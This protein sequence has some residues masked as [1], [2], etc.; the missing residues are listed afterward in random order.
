MRLCKAES[1]GLNHVTFNNSRD[2]LTA[3][4]IRGSKRVRSNSERGRD[5]LEGLMPVIEDWH[6]KRCFLMVR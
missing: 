5:W 3:A 6:A 4:R 2:Q 1:L